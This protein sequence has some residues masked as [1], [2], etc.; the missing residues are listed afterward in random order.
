MAPDTVRGGDSGHDKVCS[1]FDTSLY[2]AINCIIRIPANNLG[3]VCNRVLFLVL[4]YLYSFSPLLCIHEH[5]MVSRVIG[6]D[7]R[8]VR[9]FWIS[10]FSRFTAEDHLFFTEQHFVKG[11]FKGN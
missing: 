3:R 2:I 4:P 1:V 5:I 10:L 9:T 6:K 11:N 7:S 8:K